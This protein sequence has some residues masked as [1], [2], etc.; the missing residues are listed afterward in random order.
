MRHSSPRRR[1]ARSARLPSVRFCGEL[2]RK[3]A[4]RLLAWCGQSALL[5]EQQKGGHQGVL[6]ELS[7]ITSVRTGSG[8]RFDRSGRFPS[9]E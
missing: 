2:I 1:T 3:S 7:Q 8:D 9:I 5:F 4:I 6:G